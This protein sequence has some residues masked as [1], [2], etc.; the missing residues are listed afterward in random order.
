[1]VL[2]DDEIIEDKDFTAK[3]LK[4]HDTIKFA[5]KILSKFLRDNYEAKI[6]KMVQN[7]MQ[8]L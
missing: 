2:T 4:K 3:L 1:L 8:F 6:H 5:H 7:N